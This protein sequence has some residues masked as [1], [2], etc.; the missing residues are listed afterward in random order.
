MLRAHSTE[1][2]GCFVH[3]RAGVTSMAGMLNVRLLLT[4]RFLG[5]RGRGQEGATL[6]QRLVPLG[7]LVKFPANARERSRTSVFRIDGR[8]AIECD[9]VILP[10]GFRML[11]AG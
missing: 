4:S 6:S 8:T 11:S 7:W 1:W 5:G 10:R 2:V 9:D 3:V